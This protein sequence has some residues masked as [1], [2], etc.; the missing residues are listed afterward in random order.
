MD[1]LR[2]WT[3]EASVVCDRCL[4][5]VFFLPDKR[6]ELFRWKYE[7]E[8]ATK[9][10]SREQKY[11]KVCGWLIASGFFFASNIAMHVVGGL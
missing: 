3:R 6:S 10:P 1:M 7:L 4:A 5:V 11:V 8:N 9:I 2:L